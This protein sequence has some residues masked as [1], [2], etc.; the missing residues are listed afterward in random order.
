MGITR[1]DITIT[2][3]SPLITHNERLA[4]PLHPITQ[5]L[6]KAVKEKKQKG[7]DPVKAAEKMARLEHEGGGYLDAEGKLVMP[8]K[9]LRACI[10]SAAKMRRE[11]KTLGALR[12]TRLAYPLD[13]SKTANGPMLDLRGADALWDA[14]MYDQRMVK[15]GQARVLRTRPSFDYWRCAFTVEFDEGTLETE[16][17]IDHVKRAGTSLGLCDGRNIGF[18]R[19]I[20]SD[21]RVL[22]IAA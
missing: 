16:A 6:A 17:V 3:T 13:I 4:N 22:S 2:G 19:F 20:V 1:I 14:G 21:A 5:V 15:V 8:A 9:C 10:L 12:F 18:G 11:G 7:A